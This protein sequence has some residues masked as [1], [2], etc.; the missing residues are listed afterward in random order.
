MRHQSSPKIVD[1]VLQT[2]LVLAG[3]VQIHASDEIV[4]ELDTA[5]EDRMPGGSDRVGEDSLVSIAIAFALPEA[6][7]F[8][9]DLRE[10]DWI[11]QVP[12]LDVRIWTRDHR[13]ATKPAPD[14]VLDAPPRPPVQC[15]LASMAT[16]SRSGRSATPRATDCW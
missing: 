15:E 7:F 9:D 4:R 5:Q 10:G 6:G 8:S 1:K 13:D 2:L 14:P 12:P 11:G 16:T 3:A